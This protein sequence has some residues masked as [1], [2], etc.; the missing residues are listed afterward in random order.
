[1]QNR[2]FYIA[3]NLVLVFAYPVFW[4]VSFLNVKLRDGLSGQREIRENLSRFNARRVSG[5]SV[6]W[7]HAASAGEFEQMKP[8]IS[9]LA[10]DERYHLV[11]TVTSPTIYLKIFTDKRF[12][13]ILYLPWD[14]P[15]RV[16]R[17]VR[18]LQPTIFI[19]TRHD[20]WPNL[21]RTLK[22]EKI[23]SI[24]INANLYGSSKRLRPVWKRMNRILFNQIDHIFT[25]TERLADNLRQLYSGPIGV[26]G[27]TRFDQVWERAE[28]N[29]QIWFSPSVIRDRKVVIYGSV[30][31]S[32]LDIVSTA[33][34]TS[35]RDNDGV[36]H[37]V[38]P[39]EVGEREL[40]P[41]EVSFFR[42]NVKSARYTEISA[43]AGEPVLIWNNMGNLADLYKHAHLAYVGAGFSTG[44]HSV[45]EPAIYGVPA[46]HGPAYDL[47]DEAIELVNLGISTVVYSS[48]DLTRFL[49]FVNDPA[50][51][52]QKRTALETFTHIYLGATDRILA[53]LQA[54][55]YSA[56][57]R[58]N[59]F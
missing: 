11:Q 23:P 26:V 49:H 4:V 45:T 15:W 8:L 59:R 28:Q 6:I 52:A 5:R 10:G 19:N 41:W 27:D 29:Q 3:Y 24:L 57:H 16:S 31:A 46:A 56:G 35:V 32:D 17:F 40:V 22:R 44:V 51:L 34:G 7:L 9:R 21:L 30:V 14:L 43:Y 53:A 39:H 38:V 36:L 18:R 1:M 58:K 47:L 54:Y 13:A 42:Q 25:G 50:V 33:I 2:L 48:G 12:D 55:L 37:V 20:L